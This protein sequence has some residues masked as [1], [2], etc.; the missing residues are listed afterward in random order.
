MS[1]IRCIACY[2]V[3]YCCNILLNEIYSY[4]LKIGGRNSTLS[5]NTIDITSKTFGFYNITVAAYDLFTGYKYLDSVEVPLFVKVIHIDIR[6]TILLLS[7]LISNF[8]FILVC[9]YMYSEPYKR[10]VPRIFT[11]FILFNN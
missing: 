11:M 10:I 8:I 5:M 9:I 4:F 1:G 2:F 7:N 3:I 6:Q